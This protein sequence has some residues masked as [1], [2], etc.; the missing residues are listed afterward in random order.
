MLGIEF[1][2][3]DGGR[4][5][6]GYRGQA[7]DCAVR[8]AAIATGWDY[9]DVY[10][11][12]NLAAQDERPRGSRKRSNAR[13]GVWPGTLGKVLAVDG[14]EWVPTM[15]IGTGCTVH[16]SSD[17]LPSGRLVVRVSRHFAAV[18]DGVLHD[19]HDCSRDGLRCVYGF[20]RQVV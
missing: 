6:A 7:G 5:A 8:A 20:W 19:T 12:I 11:S 9:E 16:L 10:Q 15:G 3:D 17:E 14:F 13:T 2:E 4:A 1:V 18:I